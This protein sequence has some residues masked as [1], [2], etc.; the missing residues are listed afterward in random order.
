MKINICICQVCCCVDVYAV[1]ARWQHEHS[2]VGDSRIMQLMQ[3]EANLKLIT[4]R[5]SWSNWIVGK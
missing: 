2:Y 1:T 5:T 4:L 3:N